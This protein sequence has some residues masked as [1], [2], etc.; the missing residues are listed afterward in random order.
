M[1]LTLEV[2]GP[3]GRDAAPVR[4]TFGESGGTIGRLPDNHLVLADPY[5]SNRHAR[6][7]WI[8]GAFHIEDLGSTNGVCLN[9]PE[10]RLP[11]ST[12]HPLESGDQILIDPYD[13]RVSIVPEAK[14]HA[15]VRLPGP[16]DHQPELAVLPHAEPSPFDVDL[17][18]PSPRNG[19]ITPPRRIDLDDAPVVNEFFQPPAPVASH[20]DP[21][22]P[23]LPINFDPLA[24][25]DDL[26]PDF[27]PV[28]HPSNAAVVSGPRPT[29][30]P[31]TDRAA[32]DDAAAALARGLGLQNVTITPDVAATIGQIFR[33]VVLGVMDVLQARQRIKDEFRMH[34]T[35]FQRKENNPLKFSADVEHALRYLLV[36]R[37]PAFLDPVRAF[38]DAF[39]DIR[40]HQVAILA[41]MRAAFESML[42]EFD[43]DQL[44]EEFERK[45]KKGVLASL[46]AKATYWELYR[47]KVADLAKDP[48]TRFRDLFGDEFAR[49]YEEQLGELKGRVR[50]GHR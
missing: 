25:D 16:F 36:D 31:A 28:V 38:D 42:T 13:I 14:D 47:E 1:I 12:P 23:F 49:A 3:Q 9:S 37:D 7:R 45:V 41:G 17:L 39:G 10:N 5:V 34:V 30:H 18:E 35:T 40:N 50:D 6:I 27:P 20:V 8:N 32:S 2:I 33:V 48:E 15:P 4:T 24:P 44:Q 11:R 29:P 26:V 46:N 21:P 22:G 19:R 43:P